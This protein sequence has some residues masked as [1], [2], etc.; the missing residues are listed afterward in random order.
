VFSFIYIA[1]AVTHLG[2]RRE[3]RRSFVELF[4]RRSA[5]ER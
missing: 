3:G 5:G 2:L 4:A 1:L